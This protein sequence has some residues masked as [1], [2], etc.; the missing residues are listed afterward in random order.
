MMGCKTCEALSEEVK[1]LREQLKSMTDRLVALTSPMAFQAVTNTIGD[2]EDFYGSSTQ[3]Q[4]VSYDEHGER[5]LLD[6]V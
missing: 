4:F 2:P 3:D 6:K 1:F 5:I